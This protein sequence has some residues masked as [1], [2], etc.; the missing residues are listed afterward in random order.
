MFCV[1]SEE[2]GELGGVVVPAV[3]TVVYAPKNYLVK[4][5]SSRLLIKNIYL[6][7]KDGW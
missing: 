1:S 3:T 5:T 4:V 7:S 6:L 2:N